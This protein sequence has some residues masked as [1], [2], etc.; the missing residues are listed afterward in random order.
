MKIIENILSFFV[1]LVSWIKYLLNP[2]TNDI[3]VQKLND[4]YTNGN[5]IIDVED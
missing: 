5:G 2:N 4:Y 3:L 1:K